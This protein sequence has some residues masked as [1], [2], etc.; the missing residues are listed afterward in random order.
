[1]VGGANGSN[2][3]GDGDGGDGDGMPAPDWRQFVRWL[4][5]QPLVRSLGEDATVAIVT[6]GQFLQQLVLPCGFGHPRNA[7]VYVGYLPREDDEVKSN[8]RP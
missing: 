7:E 3:D 8:T 1:M 2:G 5:R 6:H 4:R